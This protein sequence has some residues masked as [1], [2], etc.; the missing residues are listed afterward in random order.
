MLHIAMLCVDPNPDLRPK[1]SEVRDCINFS[2]KA[3]F[4]RSHMLVSNSDTA[5]KAYGLNHSLSNTTQESTTT[6]AREM[7]NDDTR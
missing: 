3:R 4:L 7:R 1:I 5:L 6:T 2:K